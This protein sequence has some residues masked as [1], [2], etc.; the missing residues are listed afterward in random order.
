MDVENEAYKRDVNSHS[1]PGMKS[2]SYATDPQMNLVLEGPLLPL[3]HH[4]RGPYAK[5]LGRVHHLQT[6]NDG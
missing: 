2:C 3:N 5:W 1:H 4:L 6:D